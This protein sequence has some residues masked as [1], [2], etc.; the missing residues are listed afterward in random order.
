MF[1]NDF[2]NI[3]NRIYRKVKNE[4]KNIA[5]SDFILKFTKNLIFK[6]FF[7]HF[8]NLQKNQTDSAISL[9]KK[10]DKIVNQTNL[11]YYSMFFNPFI[12]EKLDS[13]LQLLRNSPI[14]FKL[15][16]YDNIERNL[17]NEINVPNDIFDPNEDYSL[18][19]ILKNYEF[20]KN[21][22]NHGYDQKIVD[23][24]VFSYLHESYKKKKMKK[25][26]GLYYTNKVIINFMT[27]DVLKEY[28]SDKTSIDIRKILSLFHDNYI[29]NP[30]SDNLEEN[31]IKSVLAALI[32]I[33]ILDP[34]CGTGSFLISMLNWLMILRQNCK[35]LLNKNI[36]ID[37]EDIF[38]W[39][40][41]IIN[42]SLY[43]I[44]IDKNALEIA[45]F[46]LLFN[47]LIN[48]NNSNIK[49][50]NFK[51]YKLNFVALK[52]NNLYFKDKFDIIIGNPPYKG[53]GRGVTKKIAKS[54]G[55]VSKDIFGIFMVHSLDFL[56]DRGYLS[57]IVT[58]TWRTIGSH[59]ALREIILNN[60]ELKSLIEL[61]SWLFN[62]AVNTSI[63]KLKMANGDENK[64]KRRNSIVSCY[65]LIGINTKNYVLLSS[66]LEKILFSKKLEKESQKNLISTYLYH[67]KILEIYS[68]NPL[69]V[70]N[71]HIFSLMADYKITSKIIIHNGR[72]IR[73]YNLNFNNKELNLLK[74]SDI[75]EVK[76]G[77]GTG[78][79]YYYI[80][81][82]KDCV[83]GN[84]DIVDRETILEHEEFSDFSRRYTKYYKMNEDVLSIDPKDYEGHVYIPYDKGSESKVEDG[85]LPNYRVPTDYYINWSKKS[86]ERLKNLTIGERKKYY[87]EITQIKEEKD[88][89][90]ASR[91]QNVKFYFKK[92]I[93]YSDTGYYAPTF[94]LNHSSVFDVMGMSI[95][96]DYYS[97]EFCLGVLCSKLIKYLI[98]NFIN[99]SVHTQVEGVKSVPFPF[100]DDSNKKIKEKIE[101]L[102][103]EIIDKQKSDEKYPYF[104][105]EQKKID[106][107]VYK[108]YN[109][110][111]NN[112]EEVENWYNRRYPILVKRQKQIEKEMIK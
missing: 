32:D 59:Q 91:L 86:V 47:D 33:K 17:I 48:N 58:D 97:L 24:E 76:Q 100:V 8:I 46:R 27:R 9:I 40:I 78:D 88:K 92:G 20:K 38:S 110:S 102:V 98:K 44:E 34:A 52:E 79:N 64:I 73:I 54:F 71:P 89:K 107:L 112:I 7:L 30:S 111:E 56:K 67:Q 43:G 105:H 70:A 31:E 106:K 49:K 12:S 62:A 6:V 66:L 95:F 96:T 53:R 61:P 80:R 50:V 13:K 42:K 99:N 63:F 68:K 36:P 94:R 93:T 4:N 109:L 101:S 75:S 23:P 16:E 51:L 55:L 2:K 11:N 28:L 22:Y 83:Y 108:L 87:K 18:L 14:N 90:I 69:I 41:S 25:K 82:S 1:L 21:S 81:K 37:S 35:L 74:F 26:Y 77:L 19:N 84:Y 104:I 29:E 57:F 85:W 3:F 45:K 5:N 10:Y 60:C 72:K 65:D 103:L 39:R 15:E